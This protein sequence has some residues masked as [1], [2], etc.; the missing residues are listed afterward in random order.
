[1]LVRSR[2]LVGVLVA[3][4]SLGSAMFVF[5]SVRTGP[6]PYD[7]PLTVG[8]LSST[9][10]AELTRCETLTSD[11]DVFRCTAELSDRLATLHKYNEAV[12]VLAAERESDRL[13]RACHGDSHRLGKLMIDQNVPLEQVL[14]LPWYDCELGLQHGALERAMS[15]IGLVEASKSVR[16]NCTILEQQEAKL[17]SDCYHIAGHI[18]VD[19]SSGESALIHGFCSSFEATR[20]EWCLN[21]VMMRLS[22]KVHQ[23]TSGIQDA[24]ITRMLGVTPEAHA[25]SIVEFCTSEDGD[26]FPQCYES[27]PIL[28]EALWGNDVTPIHAFCAELSEPA[29]ASCGH[30]IASVGVYESGAKSLDNV[31]TTC[32]GTEHVECARGAGS[33]LAILYYDHD[34]GTSCAVF[35]DPM[36]YSACFQEFNNIRFY[37]SKD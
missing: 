12:A 27:A 11:D 3:S 22:E 14:K 17:S 21:G 13:I 32:A 2:V 24:D 34:A 36:D 8:T 1:M 33:R 29:R 28:I 16:S 30:G 5:Q 31:S 20:T 4:L 6:A 37:N 15:D 19:I 25:R 9:T 23:N 18:A 35:K 10:R 26:P 7:Q